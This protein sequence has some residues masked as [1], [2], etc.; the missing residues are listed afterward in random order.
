MVTRRGGLRAGGPDAPTAADSQK[1]SE[2]MMRKH[3]KKLN[4][5]QVSAY[6]VLPASFMEDFKDRLNFVKIEQRSDSK[7]IV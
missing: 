4:W 1:L 3:L 2:S 7:P 6:Q 5:G